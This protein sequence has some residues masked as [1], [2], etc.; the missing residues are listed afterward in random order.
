MAKRRGGG[1]TV[2]GVILCETQGYDNYNLIALQGLNIDDIEGCEFS[3][4]FKAK[5]SGDMEK[6]MTCVGH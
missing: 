2:G 6:L 3:K 1:N 5:A 4:K